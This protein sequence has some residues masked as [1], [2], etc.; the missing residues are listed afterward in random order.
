[1]LIAGRAGDASSN[2]TVADG[3]KLFVTGF[4]KSVG[5]CL[6]IDGVDHNLL[7]LNLF[8]SLKPRSDI[9]L[10]RI[11]DRLALIRA[12]HEHGLDDDVSIEGFHAVDDGVD[13]VMGV[14]TV[15][16]IN[17]CGV[18]GVEFQD[19]V[20]DQHQGVVNLLAMDHGGIREHTNL[21]LR[22]VFV[23]QADGVTDDVGKMRM[24]GRFAIASKGQYIGQL[25]LGSHVL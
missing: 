9:L 19:V 14:G 3:I 12:A 21:G 23:A 17:I 8:D 4:F 5:R 7:W 10:C 25:A 22:T 2:D 6:T 18:D 20:V 24:A 11:V 13:V 1:M 16:L 15:N